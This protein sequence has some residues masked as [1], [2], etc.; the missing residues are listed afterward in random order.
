[1]QAQRKAVRATVESL[2][3]CLLGSGMSCPLAELLISPVSRGEPVHY[4]ST[5]YQ[6]GRDSQVGPDAMACKVGC[7]Q[8]PTIPEHNCAS[9]DRT[10]SYDQTLAA[11]S[12]YEA[13]TG[14][15]MNS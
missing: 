7:L 10:P 14:V 2:K 11:G 9:L 3:D 13:R 5:L 12:A 6:L 1:M 15:H 8:N 4:I